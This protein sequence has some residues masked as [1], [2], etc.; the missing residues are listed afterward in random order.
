MRPI[1]NYR[2][3]QA[4]LAS[5]PPQTMDGFWHI[6]RA[7]IVE[8]RDAAAIHAAEDLSAETAS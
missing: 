8:D 3:G 6:A 1:T 4:Y 2:L 5:N 7:V